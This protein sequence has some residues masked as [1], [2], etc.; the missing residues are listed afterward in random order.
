MVPAEC[1]GGGLKKSEMYVDEWLQNLNS[2]VHK[3]C[4]RHGCLVSYDVVEME[5]LMFSIIWQGRSHIKKRPLKPN[6]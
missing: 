6:T 2:R 5:L 4:N 1:S 3:L